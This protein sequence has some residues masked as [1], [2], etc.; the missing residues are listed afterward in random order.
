MGVRFDVCSL[1]VAALGTGIFLWQKVHGSIPVAPYHCEMTSPVKFP[2]FR[3]PQPSRKFWVS[4]LWSSSAARES[5]QC[6]R[7]VH[8]I[9]NHLQLNMCLLDACL[10]TDRATLAYILN[11]RLIAPLAIFRTKWD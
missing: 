11:P 10:F 6:E 4:K 3:S 2:P 7:D 9:S 8:R 5:S 1:A